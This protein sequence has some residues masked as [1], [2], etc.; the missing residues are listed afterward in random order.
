[1][2]DIMDQTASIGE[3]NRDY[4]DTIRAGMEQQLGI[5]PATKDKRESA[6]W[7]IGYGTT[8]EGNPN[9]GVDFSKDRAKLKE[10]IERTQSVINYRESHGLDLSAQNRHLENLRKL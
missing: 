9:A 4:I 10:E 5:D 7:T 2:S 1:M 6:S 3:S 8:G